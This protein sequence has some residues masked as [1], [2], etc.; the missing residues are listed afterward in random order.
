MRA[1]RTA[2]SDTGNDTAATGTDFTCIM[3][4][5]ILPLLGQLT[6]RIT[7]DSV[8]IANDEHVV[9]AA[10]FWSMTVSPMP[11]QVR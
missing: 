9:E 5:G 3:R 7:M 8:C 10:R 6:C 1:T 2:R 11:F 4:E